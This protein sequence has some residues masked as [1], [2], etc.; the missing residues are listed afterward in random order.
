MP[1]SQGEQLHIFIPITSWSKIPSIST[2]HG[3]WKRD[4]PVI[5]PALPLKVS[6]G[7]VSNLAL[8]FLTVSVDPF[9]PFRLSHCFISWIL[10]EI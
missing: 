3:L 2:N 5:G 9:F 1:R 8:G 10:F 7:E 6:R 4:Y